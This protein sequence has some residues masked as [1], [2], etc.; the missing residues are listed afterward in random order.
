MDIGDWKDWTLPGPPRL[1]Y[2]L[3]EIASW[4]DVSEDTLR[5]TIDAGHFPRGHKISPQSTPTWTGADLAAWLH[6]RDRLGPVPDE[7][8]PAETGRTRPKRDEPGGKRGDDNT[9]G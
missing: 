2:T 5:A 3:R 1:R 4:L 6:L 7:P 8:K 9:S